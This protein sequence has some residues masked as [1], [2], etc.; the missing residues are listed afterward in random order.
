MLVLP[1]VNIPF[2]AG[3][4]YF[5]G[6][7]LD[8]TA[9]NQ[10]LFKQ[11]PSLKAL[12]PLALPLSY[13]RS[14]FCFCRHTALMCLSALFLSNTAFACSA[15]AEL[16]CRSLS[17]TSLWT[18]LLLIQIFS[19]QP[20]RSL[21]FQLC[22]WQVPQ[23]SLL[24]N[25]STIRPLTVDTLWLFNLAWCFYLLPLTCCRRYRTVRLKFITGFLSQVILYIR[26]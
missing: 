9:Q 26:L 23:L 6:F 16:I 5:G 25:F 1:E 20:S 22:S 3:S 10:N 4:F 19:Q 15:R 2:A 24:Y 17:V 14:I 12:K 8:V 21:C 11:H 18:V 13:N 7:R